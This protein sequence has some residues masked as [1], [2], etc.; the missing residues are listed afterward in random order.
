[1]EGLKSKAFTIPESYERGMKKFRM[2]E[3]LIKLSDVLLAVEELKKELQEVASPCMKC[4]SVECAAC[5]D[6][7]LKVIKKVFGGGK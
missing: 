7:Y 1:M 2:D 3:K 6:D 4:G 5:S